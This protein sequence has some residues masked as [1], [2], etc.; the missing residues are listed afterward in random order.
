ML[1]RMVE[2]LARLDSVHVVAFHGDRG[3]DE[4]STSGPSRVVELKKGDV[5]EW[6]IDP[7]E[8]GLAHAPVEAVAG[9]SPPE[10][11]SA[12]RSVLEG[13]A[14]PRRDIVLLN[15][16]AGLVAADR[17]EDLASGLSAAAEAIDSGAASQALDRLISVSTSLGEST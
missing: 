15:A 14:G 12:I 7:A 13:D 10:N 4:L 5:R 9:G 16:A 6:K 8:L 3:L 17:A 2:A 11:A 1:E